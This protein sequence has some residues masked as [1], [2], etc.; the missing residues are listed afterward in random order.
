MRE[1]NSQLERFVK[2]FDH[3]RE[4]T[5]DKIIKRFDEY[6]SNC[7]RSLADNE[8]L[9][10][11]RYLDEMAK[12]IALLPRYMISVFLELSREQHRANDKD[13]FDLD[14]NK[15]K[16]A[17]EENDW[18]MLY[19]AIVDILKNRSPGKDDDDDED[20]PPGIDYPLSDLM[21]K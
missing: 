1:L 2:T 11:K 12:I 4:H 6:A 20:D 5:D 15:G 16:K 10:A 17:I 7:R 9:D 21:Q 19:K 3:D 8:A 18:P 14:V 13:K